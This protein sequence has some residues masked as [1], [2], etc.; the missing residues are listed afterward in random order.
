MEKIVVANIQNTPRKYSK[1]MLRSFLV[2]WKAA[3]PEICGTAAEVPKSCAVAANCSSCRKSWVEARCKGEI[4]GAGVSTR[5]KVLDAV[6]AHILKRNLQ[7]QAIYLA[8]QLL[9][10]ISGAA[11]SS[12]VLSFIT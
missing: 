7:F 4:E 5:Q 10:R 11:V 3:S 1:M 12:Q 6:M 2:H 9:Q 8:T